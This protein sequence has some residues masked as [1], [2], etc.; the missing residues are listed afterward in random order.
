M[1]FLHKSLFPSL[2]ILLAAWFSGCTTVD[3]TGRT[4]MK[5]ISDQ[6]VASM[7]VSQFE[8][9]KQEMPISN[10]AAQKARLQRVGEKVVAAA[11]ERGADLPPPSQWEFVLFE[12]DQVNAFAMP[13][14]KVGFYTGIFPLFESDDDLAVVMGHEIAHVS[15]DHGAEKVS[16][17]L[18]SQLGGAALAVGLGVGGVEADTQQI[19]MASYGVASTYGGILPYSRTMESEA[20]RIGLIYSSAA[21]YDPRVS[22]AFWQRMASQGGARP[23]EFLSTHPSENTRISNLENEII[24]EVMPIYQQAKAAGK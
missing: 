13:G 15:A 10:D 14:G 8:Q 2:A 4:Q 24:P 9:M 18:A 5:M 12:S 19:V 23:P 1:Q 21:G 11:R 16:H 7:A 20:D 22:T 3:E 17:Q 6:E